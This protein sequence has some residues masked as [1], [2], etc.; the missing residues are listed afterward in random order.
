MHR[1]PYAEI[2]ENTECTFFDLSILAGSASKNNGIAIADDKR[3]YVDTS[4]P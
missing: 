2:R 4:K 3:K 1:I